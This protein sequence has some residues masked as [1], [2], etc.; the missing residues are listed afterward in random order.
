[1][2]GVM[3]HHVHIGRSRHHMD[4]RDSINA[5]AHGLVAQRGSVLRR[6]SIGQAPQERSREAVSSQ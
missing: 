3:R 5:E 6:R 2:R 1:M 4:K